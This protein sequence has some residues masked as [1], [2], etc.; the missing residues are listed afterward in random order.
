[1]DKKNI[2]LLGTVRQNRLKGMNLLNDKEL[3]K[4]GRSSYEEK[5][6]IIE[7]EEMRAVK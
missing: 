7:N 4:K 6:A 2:H 5:A 3:L 1:M